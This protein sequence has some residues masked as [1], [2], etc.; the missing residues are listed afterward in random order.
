MIT[1]TKG[2]IE[3]VGTT[4]RYYNE[5]KLPKIRKP[6]SG[7][8][9]GSLMAF[10]CDTD[11]DG[12]CPESESCCIFN[13][14]TK[15]QTLDSSSTSSSSS[16]S[17]ATYNMKPTL[18]TELATTKKPFLNQPSHPPSVFVQNEPCLG[19][20]LLNIMAAFCTKPSILKL[21]TYNCTKG[22]V[23]CD[24]S[25]K[26]TIL[27]TTEKIKLK[28]M[29]PKTTIKPTM[30][31][32][33]I[34][35]RIECPGTCILSYLSFTCFR[36]AE[37]TDL[38]QCKKSG[39]ECCAPKSV[40]HEAFFKYNFTTHSTLEKM[41]E[42]LYSN[43][44]TPN[45]SNKIAQIVPVTHSQPSTSSSSLTTTSIILPQ[46]TM[47][48]VYNE[49]Y[50]TPFLNNT[51]GKSPSVYNKYV[52]GVKGTSRTAKVVGGEDG[53]GGEWCWHTALINSL[54]QYLC[55]AALIG[56]QWVLTA[57]HCVTNIVRS[58]DTIY[59][60]IGDHD[61]TKKHPSVGA[62]TLKVSTTYVHHNHNSQTLDNDIAL[63]KLQGQAEL[64]DGVCLV[65]LPAR[66]V[67]HAAG[68]R[69]IV[70]GYGYMSEAGPIPLRIREAEIPI[71][72]DSECIRKVNAVTE[73]IFILPASSFCAGGEEGNDACQVSGKPLIRK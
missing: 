44:N 17:T 19:Y 2:S 63:L 1:T 31:P 36:N 54:N 12:F 49:N 72:S 65:C 61:L 69:C 66:G 71:V 9:V 40:I 59:V 32:T 53:Q 39:T 57:A 8:C 35:N 23:C 64:S 6:C 24:H 60:R 29:I 62:Q 55:G 51:T 30:R 26:I 68:K 4:N 46:A 3:S 20:C 28:P 67:N 73:K 16:T 42:F 21:N 50:L 43:Q 11:P 45:I 15:D 13:T 18:R 22:F 47:S 10:F 37:M 41:D 38:F 27:T 70:T 25:E 52:C 5:N 14:E 33:M 7:E 56:T 34:D 58:G 48:P